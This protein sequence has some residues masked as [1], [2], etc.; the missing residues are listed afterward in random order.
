MRIGMGINYAGDF[1]ETI[2]NLLEFEAAGLDRVA[3]PEAYSYDAVS[4]LGY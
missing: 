2:N 1:S 4:Q 3:V